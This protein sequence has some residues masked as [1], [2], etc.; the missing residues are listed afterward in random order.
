MKVVKNNNF[1]VNICK[2]LNSN[3]VVIQLDPVLDE[4]EGVEEY[5][6]DG[7]FIYYETVE[8][9]QSNNLN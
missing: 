5:H 1:A 3:K 8:E 6:S 7:T 2:A 9:F 4:A